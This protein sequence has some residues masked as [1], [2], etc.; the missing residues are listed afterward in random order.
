MRER[1]IQDAVVRNFE[2]IVEAAN[3]LSAEL[4]GQQGVPW[5]RAEGLRI[6]RLNRRRC[7]SSREPAPR[8]RGRPSSTGKRRWR[9]AVRKLRSP[10][11]CD[12]GSLPSQFHG[13]SARWSVCVPRPESVD[14]TCALHDRAPL[15]HESRKTSREGRIGDDIGDMA[16]DAL[17]F[18][19]GRAG[20]KLRV[21]LLLKQLERVGDERDLVRPMPVDRCFADAGSTGS[22]LYGERAVTPLTQLL[23][24]RL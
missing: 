5:N 24:H 9:R 13:R 20:N 23:D 7:Q 22:G 15:P 3:R 12:A 2:I 11:R 4:R 18:L 14:E 1:L 17:K 21:P 8:E 6:S 19:A 10:D 16:K